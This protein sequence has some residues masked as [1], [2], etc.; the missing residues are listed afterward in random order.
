MRPTELRII[1]G[2]VEHITFPLEVEKGNTVVHPNYPTILHN[3]AH[4]VKAKVGN[5]ASMDGAGE[6]LTFGDQREIC[7]GN[8]DRCRH[9]LMIS[10][11]V[12]PRSLVNNG[13]LLSSGPYHVYSKDGKVSPVANCF[14][15]NLL[16]R[17]CL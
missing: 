5:G 15:A 14:E 7:M 12:H 1:V 11:Y 13:Y 2:V 8:I 16:R 4:L 6:Y 3:G 10:F 17:F 9:G